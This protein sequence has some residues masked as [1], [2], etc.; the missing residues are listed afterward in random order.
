MHAYYLLYYEAHGYINNAIYREKEIKGWT[1]EKKMKLIGEFNPSLEF[2]NERLFG[3]W[4][5]KQ[6]TSRL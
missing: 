6:I 2:L 1:R 4:P 3:S 5:P